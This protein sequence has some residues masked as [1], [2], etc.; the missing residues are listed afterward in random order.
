MKMSEVPMGVWTIIGFLVLFSCFWIVGQ[1]GAVVAYDRVAALGLHP[2]R[3][4]VDP[5]T[6]LVTQ[7]IAVADVA[8]QLPFFIVAI[9]GL[10]RLRFYG[11]VA[12][13]IGLG[14]N[15]YWST[16]AWAKQLHYLQAGVDTVPFGPLLH[17]QLAFVF[18]FSAWASWHLFR[19]RGLFK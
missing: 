7:A 4:L 12:A 15:L 10:W 9:V 3:H 8:I 5:I 1:G 18:L 17:A 13:W 2:E 16:V 14:I 11:A 6:V 19:I